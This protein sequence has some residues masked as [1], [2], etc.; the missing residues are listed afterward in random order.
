MIKLCNFQYFGNSDAVD[1]LASIVNLDTFRKNSVFQ[2][3]I[4]FVL[5]SHR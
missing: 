2:K 4:I 1:Q 5:Y 3:N